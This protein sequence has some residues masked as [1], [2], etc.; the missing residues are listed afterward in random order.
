MD[1]IR[2]VSGEHDLPKR[3]PP[4]TPRTPQSAP[5]TGRT[6]SSETRETVQAVVRLAPN[7]RD[8]VRQTA[9]ADD[10]KLDRG[11]VSRRVRKALD[12]GY[13]RNLEDKR[14]KPH[15]LL[16]GDPLPDEQVILPEPGSCTVARLQ[17][18]HPPRGFEGNG[19][20]PADPLFNDIDPDPMVP[21]PR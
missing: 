10:V 9:L 18:P 1:A 5:L 21:P 12:G 13:L 17:R 14:G 11:T 15:R 7:H 3:S 20:A 2:A 16:P 19:V 6:V 8:G 4:S